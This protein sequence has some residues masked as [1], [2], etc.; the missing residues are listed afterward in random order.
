MDDIAN[1]EHEQWMMK[2]IDDDNDGLDDWKIQDN[3]I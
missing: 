3:I 2:V 1:Y